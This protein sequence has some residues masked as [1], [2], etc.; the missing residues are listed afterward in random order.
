MTLHRIAADDEVG[1]IAKEIK[2]IATDEGNQHR[3]WHFGTDA[4][5]A[6]I[7]NRVFVAYMSDA[8]QEHIMQAMGLMPGVG[9]WDAWDE[10]D[11]TERVPMVQAASVLH[12][13]T[14]A[15]PVAEDTGITVAPSRDR[16]LHL[17]LVEDQIIPIDARY[18]PFLAERTVY[19]HGPMAEAALWVAVAGR[20][21]VAVMRMRIPESDAMSAALARVA[22]K[23]IG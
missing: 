5:G 18:Q 4:H 9:T 23:S 10:R 17:Y 12:A 14:E 20:V 19:C 7:T 1:F 8:E 21:E 15:D 13:F 3:W 6:F 11:A 2:R 16:T 22:G